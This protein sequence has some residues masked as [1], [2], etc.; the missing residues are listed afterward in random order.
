MIEFVLL[1]RQ[2]VGIKP[3][4]KLRRLPKTRAE[5]K[6]LTKRIRRAERHIL[7]EAKRLP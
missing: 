5:Q 7:V 4:M 3:Y 6:S 2:Y 1:S